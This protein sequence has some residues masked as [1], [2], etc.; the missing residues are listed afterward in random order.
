[1]NLLELEY[2]QELLIEKQ[3]Y[4]ILNMTKFKEKSSF[5]IEY[6]LRKLDDNKIY[7]LNVEQ[8]LKVILYEIIENTTIEPKMSI[9]F[10]EQE[11]E[12]YEKGTEKVETYYGM[13]DVGLNEEASYYEYINKNDN[14]Q[15]ISIE[16]WKNQLEVS[17]GK[18]I[19][20]NDIK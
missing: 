14:N 10:Q 15:F 4:E 1:M 2:R 8:S 20:I 17:I 3:K 9:N 6:K 11:Y 16:K 7:Y 18:R 12:L 19:K 13:T 5:W